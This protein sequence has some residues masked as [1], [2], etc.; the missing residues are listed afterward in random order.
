MRLS[1]T[2]FDRLQAAHKLCLL[3]AVFY[4]TIAIGLGLPYAN[5]VKTVATA[6]AALIVGMVEMAKSTYRQD[7]LNDLDI[8]DEIDSDMRRDDPLNIDIVSHEDIDGVG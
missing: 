7:R 8:V 3:L 1:D 4:E 2:W 5:E 6:L